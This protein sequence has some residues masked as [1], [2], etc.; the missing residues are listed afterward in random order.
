MTSNETLTLDANALASLR[1]GQ[2]RGLEQC[3]RVYGARVY[4]ICRNLLPQNTDAED[5][6]QEVF[7]KVMERIGQFE[8]RASFS[9]WLHRI[10][11]NHCLNRIEKERRRQTSALD[12]SLPDSRPSPSEASALAEGNERFESFLRRL[13][14]MQRAVLVLREV[15]QMS[16]T[17]ISE[18]LE[19]PEGTVMSRLARGR[20]RLASMLIHRKGESDSRCAS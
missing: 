14:P 12:D 2:A 17:E 9:T 5:A 8:G 4:R 7:L 1:S 10:A 6:T 16:Y 15:E 13:P 11:V 18:A 3:Y 20:E 19:I